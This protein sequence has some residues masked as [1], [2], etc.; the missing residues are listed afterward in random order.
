[1]TRWGKWSTENYA[2]N[3]NLTIWPMVYRQTIIS[4][5]EWDARSERSQASGKMNAREGSWKK[6]PRE[7][8][9]KGDAEGQSTTD[10][11]RDESAWDRVQGHWGRQ[12]RWQ[13]SAV[14]K[15]VR[16]ELAF[17]VACRNFAQ[18]HACVSLQ[19]HREFSVTKLPF[20]H[21]ELT[22]AHIVRLSFFLFLPLPRLYF[23]WPK[24]NVRYP[25]GPLDESPA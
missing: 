11:W 17:L 1:M 16:N 4:L 13:R 15:T 12:T 20:L 21:L 2:R 23:L 25:S 3:W 8:V 14:R 5:G 19:M 7:G 6:K 10:S 24:R 18:I 9:A 22:L